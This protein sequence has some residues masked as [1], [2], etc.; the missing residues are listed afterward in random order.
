MSPEMHDNLASQHLEPKNAPL[1][2]HYSGPQL[3]VVGSLRGAPARLLSLSLS[4]SL[5]A[6]SPR[7]LHP[8]CVL[9]HT[10]HLQRGARSDFTGLPLHCGLGYLM[11]ADLHAMAPSHPRRQHHPPRQN[12][13]GSPSLVLAAAATLAFGLPHLG[14][15]S[16][17]HIQTRSTPRQA[18]CAHSL[19]C[20]PQ[21][22]CRAAPASS[23]KAQ[24]QEGGDE[25]LFLSPDDT[26]ENGRGAGEAVT[27]AAT[28]LPS[29]QDEDD[30]TEEQP[31]RS[32]WSWGRKKKE[33]QDEGG[34]LFSYDWENGDRV[35][36]KTSKKSKA[37]VEEGTR[38]LSDYLALPPTEYSLLDPK[39]VTRLSEETFRMDGATLNIV[40]TKVKPVIF[41]KVKV[42]PEKNLA[43]IMV[44]RVEL[45]GSEAVRGAAG[46]FN[47]TS[48][49]VVS[50]AE[51][52]DGRQANL[53]ELR[54]SSDIE[55][56]L[57]VPNEN[58]VPLG[59]LRRA[60]NFVMQRVVDIGLP[61]FTKFLKRDYARWAEGD[62]TRAAVVSEGETLISS[63]EI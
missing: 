14:R 34:G 49:T 35:V 21:R 19:R 24:Q 11:G 10:S 15:A 4:L 32:R 51:K 52:E 56:E 45:D 39:M 38:K 63:D 58:F 13:Q 36:W 31:K 3:G 57:L 33:S 59:V 50:C 47:V 55:I 20:H 27:I 6:E 43:N 46:T 61:Q 26:D 2:P 42:E 29:V 16:L 25:R 60:G 41:V 28:G 12:H 30:S 40:G 1:S 37:D 48:S 53:L 62:D 17:P 54:T 8:L 22:R 23:P 7:L 18:F 5:G 9:W 44:E